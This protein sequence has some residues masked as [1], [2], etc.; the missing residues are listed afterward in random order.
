VAARSRLGIDVLQEGRPPLVGRERERELLAGT[1]ARVRAEREPQL[2]TLIGVP[3]IG[4][5]RLVYELLAIVRDDPELIYWR[6]GR[7][8]PYGDG[9]TFWALS[10]MV[11]A[12]AGILETDTAEAA[13]RKL[14]EAV[15]QACPG[16]ADWVDGHLR[17]LVGLGGERDASARR[18]EAFAA[19]R[20]FFEGL[21]EERSLV[22]VFED[23][24]WADGDLLDFVDHL[25]DWARG[26]PLLVVGTARPELL[27]GR[28]SW[29]GGKLNAST[30]AL[31]PL[32]DADTARLLANLLERSV[33]PAESQAELLRRAAGNPLYAEEFARMFATRDGE[34]LPLPETVQGIIAARLDALHAEE[35]RLLQEAAVIGKVFWAGALAGDPQA[36]TAHLH[37]LERTEFVRRERRSSVAGEDEYV[38]R[39]VLVRDVAYGQIPRAERARLHR[40]A[41]DWI[42]SLSERSE[43]HAE[44]LAHHYLSALEHGRAAGVEMDDVAE[45]AHAALCEAGERALALNAFAAAA[46][47]FGAAAELAPDGSVDWARDSLQEQYAAGV[48]IYADTDAAVVARAR[49]TLLEA[50]DVELAAEAEMMLSWNAWNA[51]DAE[52]RR[53]HD[54]RA[55][56][57]LAGRPPSASKATVLSSRA[58]GAVL[59]ADYEHSIALAREASA[60]ADELD[61]GQIKVE[62][63]NTIGV[64]RSSSGDI[65]GLEDIERSMAMAGPTNARAT[66]RGCKNLGTQHADLGNLGESAR[67]Y[68]EGLRAA[69]RFGDDFNITWFEGEL[70]ADDY[71]RGRWA[72]ALERSERFL[73]RLADG[74]H[75]MEGAVRIHRAAILLARGDAEQA[76]AD[77]RRAVEWDRGMGDPQALLPSLARSA[78]VCAELGL[79]DEA[80]ER[81]MELLSIW[82]GE[83]TSGAYWLLDAGAVARELGLRDR[84][85]KKSE[86]VRQPTPWIV[87]GRAVARGDLAEAASIYADAG[88]RAGEAFTRLRLAR[89]LV[90]AGRRAEADVELQRAL[91]FYRSVGAKR[92]VREGESLLAASA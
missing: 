87:A 51:G 91:A 76:L 81:A 58:V 15:R 84:F 54:H 78:R 6:Q 52:S 3:G 24:H 37:S 80:H 9:V 53:R 16:D 88:E 92:Y 74:T 33:L 4:K 70:V 2:V 90:G 27:E 38:F 59:A 29:G 40:R 79:R 20:R 25:V 5:S 44:L 83:V 13:G 86:A 68:R 41:A 49:D 66:I 28:P 69:E 89:G 73:A 65:G 72:D 63:M 42:D 56:E 77:A 50:G 30:V 61:L 85:L 62:C 45:R 10:E 82:R 1:L 55:A 26:V 57:L 67:L 64:A 39:H 23:L 43:D 17:P 48:G 7:C 8:L 71:F 22:L 35:K 31:S 46:R 32:S 36:L 21:A 11:K 18:E 60:I 75:Y 34:S 12:Q 47:L 19:W 14:A